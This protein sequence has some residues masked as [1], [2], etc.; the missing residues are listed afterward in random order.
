MPINRNQVTAAAIAAATTNIAL[1][2]SL[3]GAGALTLNGA[4]ATGGVATLTP[5]QNVVITSAGNDSG[6]TWTIKGFDYGGSPLSESLAGANGAVTSKYI[7]ASVTSISGSGATASTVTAGVSG[8]VYSPWLVLGAQR[9]HYQW[10]ARTFIAAGGASSYNIEV[11][12]D[13]NLMNQVGGY[14]DDIIDELSNQTGNT[15][16]YNTTP[17]MG[18]RLKC[19]AGGGTGTVTLRALE[20]RT[21]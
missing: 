15:T 6:L 2:Q 16:S 9:N 11:T 17:W 14:A 10:T 4:A 18:I 21:A 20:S 8:T 1:S 19:N 7:Y 12:S 3:A 13:I 5:A